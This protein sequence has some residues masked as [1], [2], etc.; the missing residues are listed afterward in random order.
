MVMTATTDSTDFSASPAPRVSVIIPV[1]NGAAW[2]PSCLDSV[3]AQMLRSIEIIVVDDGSTDGTPHILREYSQ[4]R[5]NIRVTRQ[6]NAGVSVARNAGL[7]QARGDYIAFVDAD[8]LMTPAMLGILVSRADL[9]QLDLVFCNAWQHSLQ[10]EI[11]TIF[12]TTLLEPVLSGGDWMRRRVAQ[13]NLRHYVWCQLARREWLA[14]AGFRFVPGITHQD[15]VWTNALLL[16]ARRVGYEPSPLYHYQQ[17]PGSLSKPRDSR[18][19]RDAALHYLRV[20]LEL[21][22][23][24]RGHGL[25]AG[26]RAALRRQIVREGIAVFQLARQLPEKERVSVFR[27]V[28]NR[29]FATLLRE[30]VVDSTERRRV[31]RRSGRYALWS[32]LESLR[33]WLQPAAL[34]RPNRLAEQDSQFGAD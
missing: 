5:A 18:R 31:W 21:A 34:A 10:G 12:P 13:D 7:A 11:K 6:A 23:L 20:A 2:L 22:V 8:D 28:H 29:G 24:A 33:G 3:L 25:S 1:H 14:E 26:V 30:A 15:I 4:R 16:R 27:A 32:L 19:L 9:D 17:R